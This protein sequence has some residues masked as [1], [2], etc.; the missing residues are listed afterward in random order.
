[1]VC[2]ECCKL[3]EKLLCDRKGT[4]DLIL[5]AE[6]ME[7]FDTCPIRFLGGL[8]YTLLAVEVNRLVQVGDSQL[9]SGSMR[10]MSSCETGVG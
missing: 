10:L 2:K 7:P 8:S 4:V 9:L 5:L 3:A 1:M 6:A